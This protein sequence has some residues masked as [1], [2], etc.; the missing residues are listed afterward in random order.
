MSK[1]Y[2]S[3]INFQ[4]GFCTVIIQS[5]ILEYELIGA[6]Y[7]NS[8]DTSCWIIVASSVK[9]GIVEHD[10]VGWCESLNVKCGQE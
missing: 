4:K 10:G 7:C 9:Y 8:V 5:M 6:I 1:T 2:P 3:P